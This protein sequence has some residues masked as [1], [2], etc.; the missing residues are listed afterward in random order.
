MKG[1]IIS[2]MVVALMLFGAFTVL[3]NTG[4]ENVKAADDNGLVAYWDFDEGSG[5]VLYDRSGNG[6]DG[7][8]Y[9]AAWVDGIKGK[10]LS[11]DGNNDYVEVPHSD[12]FYIDNGTIEFWFM[13]RD[14]DYTV[15]I[16]KNL[17]GHYDD[18]G[19]GIE[20]DGRLKVDYD[21]YDISPSYQ[22]FSNEPIKTD[23]WYYIALTWGNGM[24]LYI[25]GVLEDSN[26]VQSRL[27]AGTAPILIGGADEN[28]TTNPTHFNGIIDE[29]RIYN[30]T[31]SAEE[32]QAHYNEIIGNGNSDSP[33]AYWDFDE[34]TGTILHDK[35]G[36][37]NDGTIY[38]ATWVDG[39][40][41][42][43]LS[44]DGTG[45]YVDISNDPALVISGNVSLEVWVMID[46]LSGLQ[47]I[48]RKSYAGY[49][50]YMRL[51]DDRIAFKCGGLT[52]KAVYSTEL[53]ET[54]KWYHFVGVY[55]GTHLRLYINSRLDSS[56]V[57]SGRILTSD[58]SL[59]IGAISGGSTEYFKGTIDE[60][61]IYNRALSAE[62]IQ[63]HYNEIANPPPDNGGSGG[64][65]TPPPS[66]GGGGSIP[67]FE[68]AYFIGAIFISSAVIYYK[69]RKP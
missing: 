25:D 31:L 30:R 4:T 22:L 6:N 19:I 64:G 67:G 23:R 17:I 59:A 20:T 5:N 63:A 65:S 56:V 39:I 28:Y 10:A 50:Y 3:I 54:G 13:A 15:L 34:G 57:T 68:M 40:K 44:F 27:R 36:N 1:K 42:K 8:V 69:R 12:K 58:E 24:G 9:G 43:A 38:G 49:N 32:I 21:K 62:E 26:D 51:E 29:V 7:S 33:V 48:V 2:M 11:F 14:T 45:D 52:P 46:T 60:V 18:I 61:R 53:L 16:T 37:G 66:G 55:D 47:N 35:S 41:G